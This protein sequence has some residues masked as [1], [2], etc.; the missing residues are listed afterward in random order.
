MDR[1]KERLDI[2]AKALK[3]L[4]ELSLAGAV[5]DIVRD[6]AIQRFEYTFEAVWKAA[7]LYLREKEGLE[8][9]SP[10]GVVRSCLQ[11]GLLTDPQARRAMQMIDDRNLTVHTYNEEL[12][13]QIFARLQGYADLMTAWLQAMGTPSIH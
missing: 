1:L 11:V 3:T 12:A 4:T 2:A 10:K 7:Q 8:E 6:A 5:D 9:G 13:R